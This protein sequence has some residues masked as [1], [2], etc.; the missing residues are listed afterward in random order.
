MPPRH[1]RNYRTRYDSLGDDPPLLLIAPPPTA[2]LLVSPPR[3]EQCSC[4]TD[5]DHK[6]TRSQQNR[7]VHHS[8]SIAMSG[9]STT[10][11][12]TTGSR[13]GLCGPLARVPTFSVDR[14]LVTFPT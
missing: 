2:N 3:R 7:V 1:V 9:D 12:I 6:C 13:F 8:R 11:V 4:V 14:H 5:V 10:S